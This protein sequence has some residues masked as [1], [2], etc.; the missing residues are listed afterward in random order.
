MITAFAGAKA[1]EGFYVNISWRWGFG[2]F[3]IVFPAVAAPLFFVLKYNVRKAEKQGILNKEKSDKSILQ[4]IWHYI[5]EFDSEYWVLIAYQ[6]M[7]ML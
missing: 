3:A 1:A 2:T 6:L 5:I 4:K 7:L